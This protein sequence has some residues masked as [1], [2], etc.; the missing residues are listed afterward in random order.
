MYLL[1]PNAIGA[2]LAG[3]QILLCLLFPAGKKA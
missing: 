2:A 1:V 3:I